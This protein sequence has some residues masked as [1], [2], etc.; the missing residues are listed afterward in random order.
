MQEMRR[1]TEPGRKQEGGPVLN[2]DLHIHTTASDGTLRPAQVVEE[3]RGAGLAVI[4]LAD[5]DTTDGI[6]EAVE[7]GQQLGV[8]VI[9]GVEI[10]AEDP[11][12]DVHILGYWMDYHHPDFQSFLRRPRS[13]RPERIAQM[14]ARLTA[15]GLPVAPEEVHA[16]AGDASSVGR[17]HLARVLLE[18]GYVENMEDAFSRYLRQGCPA[19]VKRF[20]NPTL[21]SIEHIHAGGGI[22]VI[23]HPGLVEDPS[24]VDTLIRQGVMGI[25]GYCHTHTQAT[26]ERFLA[27]AR[28][29]ELIV[30]GGSD[31]HGAMLEQSFRLGDLKVPY[32]CYE[33]LRAAKKRIRMRG[34]RP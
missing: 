30:T 10:S 9:P 25:E 19:Y 18:K 16:V 7:A 26:T 21:E 5:H 14:C 33:A 34:G 6:D 3:A 8:E 24:L 31:Y 15:L 22:S 32:A 11:R 13:A 2:I 28:A 1:P 29:H 17:P 23:A 20:K 12:G 27:L 4:A